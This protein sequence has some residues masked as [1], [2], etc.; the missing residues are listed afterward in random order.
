MRLL[1][2]ATILATTGCATFGANSTRIVTKPPGAVV[3][4]EGAGECETPCR[5]ELDRARDITIAKAGYKAQRIRVA[6][7][8]SK[9]K[10][11]LELVAP[12]KEVESNELPE[13]K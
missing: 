6:P 11:R 9:V 10:V 13:L 2:I 7:G 12:T 5:I 3:R 4:V 1:M 8:Q